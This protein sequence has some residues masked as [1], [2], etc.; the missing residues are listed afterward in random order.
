MV[1]SPSSQ[2]PVSYHLCWYTQSEQKYWRRL[3]TEKKKNQEFPCGATR[4]VASLLCQDARSIRSPG[5]EQW[6]KRSS[7]AAA[8]AMAQ[9]WLRSYPWPRNSICGGA[10]KKGN[11]KTTVRNIRVVSFSFIQGSY[12]LRTLARETAS[13]IALRDSSEEAG[14]EPEYIRLF[15]LGNTCKYLVLTSW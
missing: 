13:W 10:A 2:W 5:L 3:S 1:C 11:Q 7:I 4:S 6:G 9:L 15:W 8:A 12:L 14:E